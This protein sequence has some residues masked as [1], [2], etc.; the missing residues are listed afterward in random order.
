MAD[1]LFIIGPLL[2]VMGI[3]DL[4]VPILAAMKAN[5]GQ[6]YRY[7]LTIRLIK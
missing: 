4:I 1:Y 2:V 3:V 6:A 5:E 7:P